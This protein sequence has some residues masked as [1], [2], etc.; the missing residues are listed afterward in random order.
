MDK[1]IVVAQQKSGT[2]KTMTTV[3]LD[4]ARAEHAK[5]AQAFLALKF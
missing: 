4:V 3:Q 1:I 2:G 5:I